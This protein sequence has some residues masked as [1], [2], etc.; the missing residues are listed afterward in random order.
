MICYE[1]SFDIDMIDEDLSLT[2]LELIYYN[3]NNL[4]IICEYILTKIAPENKGNVL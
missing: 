3:H 1:F 4:M 2:L